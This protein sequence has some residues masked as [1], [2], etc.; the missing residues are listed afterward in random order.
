VNDRT[1]ATGKSCHKVDRKDAA[2]E[3]F[4]ERGRLD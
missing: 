1:S 4:I 2:A 3:N